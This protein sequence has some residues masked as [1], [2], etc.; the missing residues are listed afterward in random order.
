MDV[1]LLNFS[2]AGE[3]LGAWTWGF[4]G[5]DTAADLQVDSDGNV[6]TTEVSTGRRVQRFVMTGM[7]E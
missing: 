4:E 1:L 2:P 5:S 3:V 7:S 6:Y